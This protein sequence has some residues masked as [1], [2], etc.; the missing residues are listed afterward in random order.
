MTDPLFPVGARV[1]FENK[2]AIIGK[3]RFECAA[4][5]V[6]HFVGYELQR[7]SGSFSGWHPEA[8]LVSEDDRRT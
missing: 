4:D 2:V 5:G 3:R 6:W 1:I 7:P 8:D